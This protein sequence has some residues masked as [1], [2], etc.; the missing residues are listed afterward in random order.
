[1]SKFQVK[2]WGSKFSKG[3]LQKQCIEVEAP[4]KGSVEEVLMRQG[5]VKVHGLKVRGVE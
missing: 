5:W 1:M 4:D 2:F 3:Q